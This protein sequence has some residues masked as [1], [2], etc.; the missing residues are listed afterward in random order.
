[1]TNEINE[2]ANWASVKLYDEGEAL[3]QETKTTEENIDRAAQGG[4]SVGIQRAAL[5][6]LELA[7]E[8][9]EL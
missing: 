1:M 3:F 2:F 9:N 6:L 4:K 5:R 7:R 8:Y